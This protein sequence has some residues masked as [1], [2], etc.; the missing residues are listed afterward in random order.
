MGSN[1]EKDGYGSGIIRIINIC[2]EHILLHCHLLQD[3]RAGKIR[4]ESGLWIPATYKTNRYSEWKE[5]TKIDDQVNHDGEDEA[6]QKKPLKRQP[7]T[8]WARHNMKLDLKQRY[9]S[10]DKEM[11]HTQQIAKERLRKDKIKNIQL[12]NKNKR[13]RN[14]KTHQKNV[15]RK[16]RN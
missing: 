3:H 13:D 4:T 1:K 15:R 9:G 12:A 2:F 6:D 7:H 8:H 10:R 11:K 5:K 16:G 14:R